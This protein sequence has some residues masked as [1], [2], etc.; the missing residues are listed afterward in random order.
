M[1]HAGFFYKG[2]SD[3]VQCFMC[4]KELD[5][6]EVNDDPIQ[7]HFKHASYC[8]FATLLHKKSSISLGEYCDISETVFLKLFR[9]DINERKA[10]LANLNSELKKLKR[11]T[12]Q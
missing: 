11:R 1:A 8:D 12:K 2:N 3:L 4:C 5:N 7:E 6:W 9:D 10:V